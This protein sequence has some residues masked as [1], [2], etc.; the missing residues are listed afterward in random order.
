MSF[1][2]NRSSGPYSDHGGLQKLEFNV[3]EAM[4]NLNPYLQAR[5]LSLLTGEQDSGVLASDGSVLQE[6]S[7]SVDEGFVYM[8][9]NEAGMATEE[10]DYVMYGHVAIPSP[11]NAYLLSQGIRPH[12]IQ[13]SLERH[14][15]NPD[16]AIEWLLSN[17]KSPNKNE[18]F[19][20]M[21]SLQ[22][23]SHPPFDVQM[24]TFPHFVSE[25][26][27]LVNLELSNHIFATIPTSFI[28]SLPSLETLI[29]RFNRLRTFMTSE[30]KP[31]VS[32][33][34]TTSPAKGSPL[35]PQL[36]SN[37]SMAP[38]RVPVI[39]N[40]TVIEIMDV[41]EDLNE[42]WRYEDVNTMVR[43]RGSPKLRHLDLSDNAIAVLPSHISVLVNLTY[44]NL[45]NN[46]LKALPEELT[47]LP[48]NTLLIEG[49]LIYDLPIA[50]ALST[51]SPLLYTHLQHLNIAN[52]NIKLPLLSL[53]ARTMLQNLTN[54]RKVATLELANNSLAPLPNSL[55][56]VAPTITSLNLSRVG[57]RTLAPNEIR[58]LVT[59]KKLDLSHNGLTQLPVELCTLSLLEALDVSHNELA[60]LPQALPG[61]RMSLKKF[62]LAHN[63]LKSIPSS[64]GTLV[65]LN[66][67]N[68]H[69]NNLS[70]SC[71]D[72]LAKLTALES[73]DL[74]G[75][76]LT[77]FASPLSTLENLSYLCLSSNPLVHISA[78]PFFG[79]LEELNIAEVPTL[80]SFPKLSSELSTL[81]CL[82][83]AHV[84]IRYDAA[85]RK[86][87]TRKRSRARNLG[88]QRKVEVLVHTSEGHQGT[89]RV[90]LTQL[91]SLMRSCPH[92]LLIG[93]LTQLCMDPVWH[94][95][96]LEANLINELAFILLANELPVAQ[97]RALM[98]IKTV[99]KNLGNHGFIV[100]DQQII[101]C[102]T[103]I[104]NR[105]F[106]LVTVEKRSN[107][108]VR[109]A[110]DSLCYLSYDPLLRRMINNVNTQEPIGTM[111]KREAREN[112]T[113]L[114][115]AYLRNAIYW[116]QAFGLPEMVRYLSNIDSEV[117]ISARAKRTMNGI[118][119]FSQ[120]QQRGIRILSI[121]GG[122]T[123][124]FIVLYMLAMLEKLTGKKISD[125]FDLIVGT[126][127]GGL[128][129]GLAA[130]SETSMEE[131][132]P[133]YRILCKTIFT[134]KGQTPIAP[135]GSVRANGPPPIP[136]LFGGDN[137]EDLVSRVHPSSEGLFGLGS[138]TDL[139]R[140][141]LGESE[142]SVSE[143]K[144]APKDQKS[145]AS[146]SSSGTGDQSPAEA[147]K[148]SRWLGSAPWQRLT[149]LI[150]MIQTRSY[151]ESM[152]IETTLRELTGEHISMLDTAS[153]SN[154]KF[155]VVSS[156]VNVFPPKPYILRNYNHPAQLNVKPLEGSANLKVWE[157]IRATTAAPGYFDPFIKDDLYL[158][159]GAMSYN[160]PIA[161]AF[162]EAKSIWPNSPI[163]CILSCGTGARPSNPV[164]VTM[165]SLLSAVV[166]AATETEKTALM[167]STFLSPDIYF[168]LQPFGEVFEFPIDECRPE[169]FDE[170]E[171][172]MTSWIE[173]NMPLFVKIAEQLLGG[174]VDHPPSNSSATVQL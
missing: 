31:V 139:L 55:L 154:T 147:Q 106:G 129:T 6:T 45:S 28:F 33:A 146:G 103:D 22:I 162:T 158:V 89:E 110:L 38:G 24:T 77:N 124:G 81:R 60:S 58:S 23:I 141:S 98:A 70:D 75:N 131:A 88:Q 166:D 105:N 86:E 109:L 37:S 92:E 163:S 117:Q 12:Q 157:S 80:Q 84:T 148:E 130:W 18:F 167:A 100:E 3:S 47:S 51:V 93:G 164:D 74:G 171:K 121:D 66:Q 30:D 135:S 169:R 1:D 46:R 159:D 65:N 114:P 69:R 21:N 102:L 123:R 91:I 9:N 63:L 142:M 149:G 25:M 43:R 17:N 143:A 10:G 35:S 71:S 53:N 104:V 59:L 133:Y 128:I 20:T 82:T 111:L 173:G 32:V 64:F 96:L 41:D 83:V 145:A 113:D 85:A 29:L 87:S 126:S 73:L 19:K 13:E 140:N 16:Q 122:G 151:Y 101:G 156:R 138:S 27:H 119:L 136:P 150:S 15:S 99:C 42:S 132:K 125:L 90:G 95:K 61:L 26:N 172:F 50:N 79:K 52:N 68:L 11:M 78:L 97:V 39:K 144:S 94:T 54:Y 49:N 152:P 5:I 4:T 72:T 14:N 57:L 127:T 112:S 108:L 76:C 67:L 174:P 168:R 161:L 62:Y 118:G 107:L 170:M 48:V 36:S 137:D 56:S 160:N 2:A 7:V 34:K 44:L 120:P 155:A 134:P 116:D 8:S 153:F 165:G 115:E 40:S